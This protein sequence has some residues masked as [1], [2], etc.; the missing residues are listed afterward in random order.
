MKRVIT[1][2]LI[3]ITLFWAV[4]SVPL[5]GSADMYTATLNLDL[6]NFTAVTSGV[7]AL[8][9]TRDTVYNTFTIPNPLN[10]SASY[11]FDYYYTT[12]V[13]Q[14]DRYVLPGDTWYD[15]DT[16]KILFQF[17]FWFNFELP[18]VNYGENIL[19]VTTQFYSFSPDVGSGTVFDPYQVT[20]YGIKSDGTREQLQHLTAVSSLGDYTYDDNT[21]VKIPYTLYRLD[22]LL[23]YHDFDIADYDS[24]SLRVKPYYYLPPNYTTNSALGGLGFSTANQLGTYNTFQVYYQTPLVDYTYSTDFESASYKLSREIRDAVVA[25]GQQ[26]S[27][28]IIDVYGTE[29]QKQQVLDDISQSAQDV[30]D[31][32]SSYAAA[33]SQYFDDAE[34]AVASLSDYSA[35]PD[36][37]AAM[38]NFGDL[39]GE[40]WGGWFMTFAITFVCGIAFVS[41]IIFGKIR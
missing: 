22:T 19:K 25:S 1:F 13:S 21:Y 20:L 37:L 7:Q 41:F 14:Y 34:S 5:I 18:S 9:G 11:T 36:I 28:T 16:S 15:Y 10:L 31:Y 24:Y 17:D 40:I 33:E 38:N 8:T 4:V 2:T 39:S 3:I 12:N 30:E 23:D 32:N 6:F 29:E 35:D 27:D 26:V